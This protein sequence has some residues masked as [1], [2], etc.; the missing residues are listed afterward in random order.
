M[1]GK[2]PEGIPMEKLAPP[3]LRRSGYAKAQSNTDLPASRRT[4][5]FHFK[6]QKN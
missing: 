6:I 3:L 1:L 2:S 5:E 4:V